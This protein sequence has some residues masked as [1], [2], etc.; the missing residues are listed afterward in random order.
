MN[1]RNN[2]RL[3]ILL[4]SIG[5]LGLSIESL[6][7]GWEFWVPPLLMVGAVSLWGMHITGNPEYKIRQVSYLVYVMLMVFYHGVHGTSYYD[8]SI[9][10]VLVMVALSLLNHIYILNLLFVEYWIVLGIQLYLAEKEKSVPF[11]T[12][13]IS[14]LLLHIAIVT[15]VYFICIRVVR[16]RIEM[17][18]EGEEKESRINAV[19]AD[20]E[21]FL[22]NISH[23]LR[24][25]VNVVL[26]MSEMQIKKDLGKEAYSIKQ[27]GNRLA[28]Q[29]EDIQDYTECKRE[30]MIL[31]EDVYTCTSLIN[32][33]VVEYRMLE[34]DKNLDLIVDLDPRVPLKMRGDSKKLHKIFR[35]LL[36]NAVK[37][38]RRGGIYVRVYA[39]ETDYGVNLCIEVTDT[40]IGIDRKS[41]AMVSES[42]YQVNKKRNRNTGGIGLGLYIVYG[43]AHSMGGFVKIESTPKSG[44]TV[45][46]TIPQKVI[47]NT[48]SF[49]I[50]ENYSGDIIFHSRSDKFKVP[51][52]RDFIKAM[53]TNLATG[54]KVSLYSAETVKEI[55]HIRE[56]NE[57]SVIFM[58]EQE[59][60]DN[61]GYFEELSKN[62]VVIAVSSN[63]GFKPIPGSRVIVL[64]K[65]LYGYPVTRVIN[66][67]Y[68]ATGLDSI[69]QITHPNLRGI[70]ALIVDD[71]PM[72]L[73][74]AEGIFK[75]FEM[76]TD[77][78]GS[79][80]EAIEK[81]RKHDYDV[82]F[83]DH[84][85]PEMDGVEAMKLIKAAAKERDKKAIVIALTANAVSGARE[86]FMREGF[87][88]FIAKPMSIPEFEHVMLKVLAQ[89]GTDR[90]GQA[91]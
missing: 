65:P 18:N 11:D 87:D 7:L 71:E 81:Y 61:T 9:V 78:A 79:G 69:D 2:E 43:F 75:D 55:E 53:A 76:H 32:D 34:N 83:M 3:I 22:S 66:E 38:T 56:K 67:G 62:G 91:S 89:N 24:T 37:F 50:S 44:T 60:Q 13:N 39:E 84:M 52:V 28:Y 33:V 40:G 59:Y 41:I 86:M 74:V 35:H 19:D 1:R 73:I 21:D 54:L 57:I 68:E 47:D 10:I 26:G 72:N 12:V 82:I 88:G 64:P 25:P 14:R 36:E 31:E 27:A 51:K 5:C 49:S 42:M 30:N 20:M 63:L 29:I 85:M 6:M 17:I 80:K 48:P 58:G 45:R 70:R 46:V 23:E 77:V 16:D 8:V 4:I 15:M 90:G